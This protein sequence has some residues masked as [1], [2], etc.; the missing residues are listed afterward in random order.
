MYE[1]E[2]NRTNPALILFLFDC[3]YSMSERYSTSKT[4]RGEYL[5]NLANKSIDQIRGQNKILPHRGVRWTV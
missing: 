2:I 4:S 3:S 5:A 1:A